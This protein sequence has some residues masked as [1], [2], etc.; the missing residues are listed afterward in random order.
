MVLKCIAVD[1]G[2]EANKDVMLLK[3]I[4]SEMVLEC[5]NAHGRFD[6]P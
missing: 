6:G 1:G 2:F 3:D 5:F 4:R